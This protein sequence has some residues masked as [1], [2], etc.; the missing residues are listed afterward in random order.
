MVIFL[1][2]LVWI[3]FT[4]EATKNYE[5]ILDKTIKFGIRKKYIVK[6]IIAAVVS[7][8]AVMLIYKMFGIN[9][10]NLLTYLKYGQV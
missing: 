4:I 8:I 9:D 1:N 10:N 2:L 7:C 3:V 6:L 5:V